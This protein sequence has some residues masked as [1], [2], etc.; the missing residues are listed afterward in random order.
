MHLKWEEGAEH[1]FG[2]GKKGKIYVAFS[3]NVLQHL[4][5]GDV[6]YNKNSLR[7]VE[8]IRE[9]DRHKSKVSN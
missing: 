9:K 4:M 7:S 1:A 8:G 5:G 6:I 2:G 3:F